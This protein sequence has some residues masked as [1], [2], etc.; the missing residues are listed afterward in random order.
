[1]NNETAVRICTLGM[2]LA[3]VVVAVSRWPVV[4]GIAL[5][6]FGLSWT[7]CM[8]ILNVTVQTSAPR[9]VAARTLATYQAAVAIGV[10]LGGWAWGI[11][12]NDHGVERALL[13]SA[14]VLII[15]LFLSRWM[16]LPATRLVN[17]TGA[18]TLSDPNVRLPLTARSGPIVVEVEYRVETARARLFYAVMQRVRSSRMRNGAYG[19]SIA[20]D[21]EDPE[22]WIE[23]YHCPTWH[24]Y[25]RQ[26]NRPT[27]GE[28]DLHARAQEFHI[29]PEPVRIHRDARKARGIGTVER[30]VSRS[31]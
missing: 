31:R 22:L 19:W 20:R 14:A 28:R 18:N 9:W 16:R 24:D 7:G 6:L 4:S 30:H 13:A 3:V 5:V 26:R 11:L 1:M 25:L 8:M 29:G 27:Q 21:I 17:A 10:A 23:R 2:A 12:A 15:S